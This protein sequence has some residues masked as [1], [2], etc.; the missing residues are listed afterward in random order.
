MAV[1]RVEG[2][3]H[4]VALGKYVAGLGENDGAKGHVFDSSSGSKFAAAS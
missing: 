1:I 2:H 3:E 4:V